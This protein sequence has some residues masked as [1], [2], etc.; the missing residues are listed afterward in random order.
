MLRLD[1]VGNFLIELADVFLHLLVQRE[2]AI[3]HLLKLIHQPSQALARLFQL[4]HHHRKE[5]N[6]PRRDQQAEEDGAHHVDAFHFTTQQHGDRHLHHH[7]Q[8]H[9]R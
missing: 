8:Y 6:R 4:L 5:V 1:T 9:Q 2:I 7:R 3:A